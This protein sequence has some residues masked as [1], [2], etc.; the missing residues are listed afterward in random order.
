MNQKEWKTSGRF[1]GKFEWY[2]KTRKI[3]KS[4]QY[5]SDEKANR[6]H[7]LR[8]TEEQRK[9]NDEHYELWGHNL[10]GT[11]EYGKY[12]IFVTEEWHN[13]HHSQS[14]ETRKKMSDSRKGEKCYWYG[15][16]RDAKTKEKLSIAC[17]GKM[18]GE[19][20][21]MYG[22]HLSEEH[23][24][25]TS[26]TLKGNKLSDETK[27]KISESNKLSYTDERR[28][29]ISAANKGKVLSDETKKKIS[30]AK[31]GNTFSDEA[32]KAMSIAHKNRY[33]NMTAEE[34]NHLGDRFRGKA[35]SNEHKRRI[36]E[37]NKGRVVSDETRAKISASNKGR[38]SQPLSNEAKAVISEKSKKNMSI[39]RELYTLHKQSGGTIKWND[40]QQ[41]V[42]MLYPER[43]EQ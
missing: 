4:L 36:S 1:K 3:Q 26:N 15:K 21:Q 14:E 23:R 38:N 9:Y 40:F 33:K 2:N 43:F 19:R 17:K 25:K 41:H 34:R 35:L 30:D 12:V 39:V 32:K 37:S 10:D 24:A 6:I 16:H 28:K 42:K 20:H 29:S 5:N 13:N 22:K 18:S 7:H 31:K 27:K 11:F 8:D